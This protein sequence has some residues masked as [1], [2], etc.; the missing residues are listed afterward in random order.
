MGKLALISAKAL[1][2]L[3]G[4]R[5]L[6]LVKLPQLKRDH[7]HFSSKVRATAQLWEYLF[8]KY[9]ALLPNP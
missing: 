6:C 3:P 2:E 7:T 5:V 4:S 1:A 8:S 9:R